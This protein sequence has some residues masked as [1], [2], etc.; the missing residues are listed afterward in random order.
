M[1]WIDWS[2][3]AVTKHTLI[4]DLAAEIEDLPVDSRWVK[5]QQAGRARQRE[6]ARTGATRIEQH[7]LAEHFTIRAVRMPE[8]NYARLYALDQLS[9][10]SFD[11]V[12]LAEDVPDENAP[13]CQVAHLFLGIATEAVIIAFDGDNRRDLFQPF[14]Y[15]QLADVTGMNNRRNTAE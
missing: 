11:L 3:Q 5:L 15:V 9:L 14:D 4:H 8:D 7:G 1:S 10:G 2:R 6:S 12:K 13:A